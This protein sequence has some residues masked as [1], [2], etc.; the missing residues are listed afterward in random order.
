MNKGISP[1][2]GGGRI[3]FPIDREGEEKNEI[4]RLAGTPLI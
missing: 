2:R 1:D 4:D 3:S